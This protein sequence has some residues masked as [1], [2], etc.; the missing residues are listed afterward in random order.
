MNP[1]TYIQ[2]LFKIMHKY[3]DIGTNLT[4]R[5]FTDV[6][7]VIQEAGDKDVKKI[8]VLCSSI[9]SCQKG[10]ELSRKY[11]NMIYCTVGIH[12]HNVHN[13][14][15]D[16]IT[17]LEFVLSNPNVVAVGEIGL[18]YRQRLNDRETQIKY[19][20]EQLDMAVRYGLPVVLC[21]R[22][23]Y[24]DFCA[25]LQEYR[26]RIRGV[27]HNFV[28]NLDQLSTYINLGLYVGISGVIC[29]DTKNKDIQQAIHYVPRDKIMVCTNAPYCNFLQQTGPINT[30]A[31]I[32][33]IVSRLASDFMTSRSE[34]EATLYWNA[35]EF[36]GL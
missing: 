27:I 34:L 5:T 17:N 11:N 23:A 33:H 29:D 7:A 20:R 14:T 28:G 9:K 32:C 18:D 6:D 8:V 25:I 22:D 31:N 12:P 3:F 35:I 16:T 19:F 26:G 30:P 15:D 1:Y 13:C 21:E 4:S 24:N 2:Y 36:F 10:L